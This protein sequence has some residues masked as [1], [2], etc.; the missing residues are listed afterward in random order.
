M[1]RSSLALYTFK[2]MRSQ[3]PKSSLKTYEQGSQSVLL[4]TR[5]LQRVFFQDL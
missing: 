1:Q 4:N 2:G 3:L 5:R